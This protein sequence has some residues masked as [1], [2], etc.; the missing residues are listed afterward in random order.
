MILCTPSNR[1][2]SSPV[3]SIGRKI[4]GEKLLNFTNFNTWPN[5]SDATPPDAAGSTGRGRALVFTLP[6]DV[7]VG[8]FVH[9]RVHQDH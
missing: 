1:G 7:L 2:R 5:D 4:D 8:A 6:E 3:G 9:W